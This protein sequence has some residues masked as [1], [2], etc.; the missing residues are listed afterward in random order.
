M[1]TTTAQKKLLQDGIETGTFLIRESD[2]YPDNFSLSVRFHRTV[3]HHTISKTPNNSFYIVPKSMCNTI[4]GLI[5]HYMTACNGLCCQLTVPCPK[6]DRPSAYRWETDHSQI[7]L[8]R[9][10]G[11]SMLGEVW[12]GVWKETIPV[13]IK[14]RNADVMS[15]SRF[16]SIAEIMKKLNHVQLIQLYGVCTTEPMMLVTEFM[17]YGCLVEYLQRPGRGCNLKLSVL[18]DMAKQIA[19]GMSYLQSQSYI[20]RD[21]A[22]RNIQVT[23]GN[24]VKIADFSLTIHSSSPPSQSTLVPVK[25][26]APE[27]VKEN[28][29]TSKSDVWS[30]GVFLMELVTRG[31]IPFPQKPIEE[32]LLMVEQGYRMPCPHQCP[33]PLY[34]IMMDCWK[35]DPK[36]RPT[37]DQLYATLKDF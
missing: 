28:R 15:C 17:K 7:N 27:A 35:L 22:S 5:R 16:L 26:T 34:Q 25:W 18:V 4:E 23:E 9:C 12:D 2:S 3:R 24:R 30:F 14:I 8:K 33:D 36:E 1:K 20:H 37:F 29:F 31:S 10:I 6:N 21:L 19:S 11:T 13:G 32:V